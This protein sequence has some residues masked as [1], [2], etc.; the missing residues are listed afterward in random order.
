MKKQVQTVRLPYWRYVASMFRRYSEIKQAVEFYKRD[1]GTAVKS[2]SGGE[3]IPN[4][5]AIERLAFR[6]MVPVTRVV[7]KDGDVIEHPEVW[8]EIVDTAFSLS[9]SATECKALKMWAAGA[10]V[11]DITKQTG[12]G[13]SA[14]FNLR[15]LIVGHAAAMAAQKRLIN[16]W[17]R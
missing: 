5:T 1:P 15:N 4:M 16:V 3:R 12:V 7:L 13:R 17:R 2:T 11:L 10:S 6:D 8:I 14:F 9:P